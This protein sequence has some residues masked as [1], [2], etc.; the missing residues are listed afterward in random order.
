VSDQALIALTTSGFSSNSNL[1]GG[2][3]ATRIRV[4]IK[5]NTLTGVYII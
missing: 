1:L 2:R 4:A 5:L 3:I